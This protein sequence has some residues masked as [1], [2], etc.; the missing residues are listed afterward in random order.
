[1][2][3]SGPRP[4]VYL[5]IYLF[6]VVMVQVRNYRCSWLL[7]E[8]SHSVMPCQVEVEAHAT[9]YALDPGGIFVFHH[10]FSTPLDNVC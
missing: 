5:F 6:I 3:R 7:P 8:V 9:I 2:S 10:L 1:M 4:Q